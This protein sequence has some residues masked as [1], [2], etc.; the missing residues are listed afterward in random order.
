M[1]VHTCLLIQTLSMKT[2][3]N[4]NEVLIFHFSF[5]VTKNQTVTDNGQFIVLFFVLYK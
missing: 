3:M 2:N 5:T 1:Y 4:R